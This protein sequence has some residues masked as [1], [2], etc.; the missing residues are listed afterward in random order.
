MIRG[1]PSKSAITHLVSEA[2]SN[3]LAHKQRTLLALLGI[4]IGTA[5]VIAMLSIGHMAQLEAIGMFRAVG[6]NTLLV[7]AGQTQL[8]IGLDPSLITILPERVSGVTLTA[9]IAIAQAPVANFGPETNIVVAGLPP[10]GQSLLGLGLGEGR[11]LTSFDTNNHVAVIGAEVAIKL[12]TPGRPAVP[13]QTLRVGKYVYTIV[14][15][16]KPVTLSFMTALDVNNAVLIPLSLSAGTTGQSGVNAAFIRFDPTLDADDMSRRVTEDLT[17][18]APENSINVQS[19][20]QLIAAMKKQK[21]VQSQLLA[22]I[23]G[24]SLLVGGI[25]VMNVMLMSVM[26]RKREIGLRMAIGA[27]PKD[28]Q[29]MF[30]TEAVVLTLTGGVIGIALG[31]V[32]SFVAA[33]LWAWEF[34]LALYT[35]PVGLGLSAFAGIVFG[36]FP[37]LKASHLN[38][39]E[40]LRAD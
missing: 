13:G 28:I 38:P 9:P 31:L 36:F 12:S 33:S 26:E 20:K 10:A 35:L 6:V 14:G 25:G 18:Q 22:A 16:L 8:G 19:P 5:S 15:I 32:I 37:A 11:L 7:N 40:A 39:I 2:V 27:A 24:I 23:G 4:V 30:L 29:G 1:L 21:A 34:S 3:L 17:R